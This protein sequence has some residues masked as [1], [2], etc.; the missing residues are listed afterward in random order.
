LLNFGLEIQ[1]MLL[2][3]LREIGVLTGGEPLRL[4]RR[5]KLE[6]GMPVAGRIDARRVVATTK[7]D[8]RR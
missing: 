5:L 1:S 4:R 7:A 3:D 6:V 2:N 8:L